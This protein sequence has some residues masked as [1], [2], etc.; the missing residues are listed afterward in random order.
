MMIVMQQG[1]TEEQIRHVIERIQQAGAR[2]HP[3]RGEFVTV[4]GAIGD[5]REIVASLQLEGEP[6]V[7]KVVPILKPY[8]LASREFRLRPR[9]FSCEVEVGAAARLPRD[10]PDRR[11]L[12]GGSLESTLET[13]RRGGGRH[14]APCAGAYKPRT[15]PYA[16]QGLGELGLEI[17]ARRASTG[18]PI[19]TEVMDGSRPRW[20]HEDADICRSAPATCRTSPCSE[21]GRVSEPSCSSAAWRPRSRSGCW[22]PS[23]SRRG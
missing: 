11:A 14:D 2:A 12:L 10:R 21:V 16:F 15:S 23:T 5:D 1:A 17:L 20:S 7:E 4:I 6:G 13:A 9:R 19:V 3:S 22:P 18:M 8:K